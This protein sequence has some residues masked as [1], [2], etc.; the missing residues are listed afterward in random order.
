[1]CRLRSEACTASCF[2]FR[3]RRQGHHAPEPHGEES[4]PIAARRRWRRCR[5]WADFRSAR[6]LTC[7]FLY[8][9]VAVR[10]LHVEVLVAANW[11]AITELQI[12]H[13]ITL[14]SVLGTPV[15][16]DPLVI[17]W[18]LASFR[19]VLGAVDR[20][21]GQG[22]APAAQRG[23]TTLRPMR[24][25]RI[26]VAWGN[27][28]TH[29]FKSCVP[30]VKRMCGER[31]S[32]RVPAHSLIWV[33]GRWSGDMMIDGLPDVRASKGCGRSFFPGGRPSTGVAA[34]EL[35]ELAAGISG[36]V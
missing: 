32:L 17:S 35:R 1:M 28:A 26:L 9:L 36:I 18:L 13:L 34:G 15:K 21:R 4:P 7:W 5:A 20:S 24:I 31:C 3:Q 23:R 16:V 30:P 14:L 25:H 10:P 29:V 12:G 2:S 19:S 27:G 11:T 8:H 33:H 6:G 22:G